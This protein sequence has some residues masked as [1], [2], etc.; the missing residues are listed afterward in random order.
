MVATAKKLDKT[1][2]FDDDE[3]AES[4]IHKLRK[5]INSRNK[6][7][8]IDNYRVS[9]A[10]FKLLLSLIKKDLKET[11]KL[12]ADLQLAIYLDWISF[13]TTVRQQKNNFKIS[14]E[15]IL[16]ARRSVVNAINKNVY[17]RYVKQSTAIPEIDD[18]KFVRF[19]GVFGCIDGCLIGVLVPSY[20]RPAWR[21]RKGFTATNA[22]F[23]SDVT[24]SMLF[25]Y[26]LVGGEG[27]GSDSEVFHLA[28]SK[29]HWLLNGF[30]LADAG[31]GLSKRVLTPYR[32]VRYHL[33]EFSPTT[34]NR[35]QNKEEL[36][37]LT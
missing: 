28:A 34:N 7:R 2:Y 23:M 10:Q 32:G 12:P 17:S 15:L 25:R 4:E 8:C 9:G 33:K 29:I 3:S 26:A 14:Y 11:R 20:L 6:S 35:P 22:F 13:D 19:Q 16:K 5:V 36:F 1:P 24:N 30:I 27:S 37:N 21:C 31:Y 18:P